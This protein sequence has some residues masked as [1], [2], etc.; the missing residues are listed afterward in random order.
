MAPE[1]LSHF[2]DMARRW[3][4]AA[5]WQCLLTTVAMHSCRKHQWEIAR[6]WYLH[7][8][9]RKVFSDLAGP[10]THMDDTGEPIWAW[11]PDHR[12]RGLVPAVQFKDDDTT[13]DPLNPDK[14]EVYGRYET[15]LSLWYDLRLE[16]AMGISCY[17]EWLRGFQLC[18][19]ASLQIIGQL[20]AFAELRNKSA[21][22]SSQHLE[23][24]DITFEWI[25]DVEPWSS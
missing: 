18:N 23:D 2:V 7:R 17:T 13:P 8:I 24:V 4:I 1:I 22:V 16:T 15:E 14:L 11:V 3:G 9:W 10:P 25:M 5:R 6:A 12:W 20:A 21:A 19:R